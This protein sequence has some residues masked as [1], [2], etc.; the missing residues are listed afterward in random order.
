MLYIILKKKIAWDL[1]SKAIKKKGK[2]HGIA[3]ISK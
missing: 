2:L 1:T 3:N